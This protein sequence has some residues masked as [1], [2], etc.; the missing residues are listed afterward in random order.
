MYGRSTGTRTPKDWLKA[1]YDSQ[2]HH[3]PI[4]TDR[5]IR[6]PTVQ[7][8]SLLPLPDWA[9]SA[10][11]LWFFQPSGVMFLPFIVFTIR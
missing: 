11:I 4:G 2:F 6:T 1:R 5:G 10:L 9:T 7:G 3:T 8:L